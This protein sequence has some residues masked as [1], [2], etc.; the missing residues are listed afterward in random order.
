[1]RFSFVSGRGVHSMKRHLTGSIG[2]GYPGVAP[3]AC[4]TY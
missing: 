3:R 4:R 2:F 1:M